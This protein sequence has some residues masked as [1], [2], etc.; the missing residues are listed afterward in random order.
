MIKESFRNVSYFFVFGYLQVFLREVIA[1][2]SLDA[3]A[4]SSVAMKQAMALSGM[5]HV[6]VKCLLHGFRGEFFHTVTFLIPTTFFFVFMYAT[7][8]KS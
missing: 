5:S 3:F 7:L 1:L 6:M 2:A 8:D 4:E